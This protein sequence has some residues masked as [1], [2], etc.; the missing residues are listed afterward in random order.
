MNWKIRNRRI[1]RT[2]C[3]ILLAVFVTGCGK[4]NSEVKIET[5]TN[6]TKLENTKESSPKQKKIFIQITGAIQKP[7]VYEVNEGDR[8]F[9]IVAQAGGL[10][11]GASFESVNQAMIAMDGQVIHVLTKDEYQQNQIP[12]NG[13]ESMQEQQNSKVN[14]NRANQEEL[15]TLPGIGEGKAKQIMEY[16]QENGPFSQIEDIM[17]ISGIKEHLFEKI[18]DAICVNK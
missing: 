4:Q 3:C 2:L 18:K 13:N 8:I 17:K 6:T 9:Q 16:R 10:L 11:E 15:M 5:T 14:I 1:R 7:G 12:S